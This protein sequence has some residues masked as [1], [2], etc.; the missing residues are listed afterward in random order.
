[1]RKLNVIT[2]KTSINCAGTLL[3][4]STAKVMG[5]LNITPDSFYDGGRLSG[6]SQVLA[7]AHKLIADGADILDLG[8]YSTRP[9]AQDISPETEWERLAPAISIIREHLPNALISVDTFRAE[10]ANK[11]IQSGAHMVNDISGGD[12]DP[13]MFDALSELQVPYICMHSRGNPQNM[14][15]KTQ[16]EDLLGEIIFSL[17]EKLFRLREKKVSDV[18]V[19]P[20]IGFAKTSEQNFE[21][22]ARLSE[23]SVLNEP[24]LV[25]LSR[26]SL[27]YKTLEISPEDSLNGTS[28][29]NALALERGANILRV[30]D[31]KEASQAIKLLEKTLPFTQ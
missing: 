16:Y 30:H 26:K 20:G 24:L 10:V 31:A 18:I 13:E 11:A 25:G 4:L 28:V 7:Q 21:L 8:G 6:P 9:G 15:Q 19:D 22:I 1:V 27:I 14:T 3:D 29:L 23:F 5:I 17:S 12:L 2:L